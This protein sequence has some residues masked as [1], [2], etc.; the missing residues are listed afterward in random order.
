MHE[1][2]PPFPDMIWIPSATF[3]MGSDKHYV[4]E[5]PAHR[6]TVDGFWIDRYPVTNERFAGFVAATGHVTIAEQVPEAAQYPGAVPELLFAGSMVFVKPDGPVDL[7]D[8]RNW[9]TFMR[10]ANWRHPQGPESSVDDRQQHPVVHVA[11]P[12][13]ER[14]AE[15]A[16][17]T[18][19]TEAE[20]ELA[21]RGGLDGAAY[22]WG[23]A[24][25]PDDTHRANTWQG[26]F[27]W[28]NSTRDGYEG[29]SPVD[30]FPAN[31]YGV[32][33]MIGNTWEW[34][35]DWYQPGHPAE[36]VQA[37]CAPKNPRGA[38]E[39]DSVDPAQP[40][41]KIPRKVIKGGSHLCAPNYC[42]RYRPAAR[43][44]EPIDTSTSHLGFRCIVRAR[45]QDRG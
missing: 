38:Q 8:I 5:R 35:T 16:G 22:A 3:T 32:S 33:D 45:S 34:T 11:F 14:F 37:C 15:W 2:L 30:A 39:Q 44:P 21:A 6:V 42:R 27:P 20:W 43:F 4:E 13:A 24:F 36:V 28:Q 25:L 19:P 9:W 26:E 29:T 10:G 7:K 17:R 41:I 1:P 40:A 23:E 18:L 12:D 31:G